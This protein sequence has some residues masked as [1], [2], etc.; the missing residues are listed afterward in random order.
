MEKSP[1]SQHDQAGGSLSAWRFGWKSFVFIYEHS[2]YGAIQSRVLVNQKHKS[3]VT[4]LSYVESK[5]GND[6]R[7]GV[8]GGRQLI[9]TE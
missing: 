2:Q 9:R 7:L 4:E 6:H 8:S 5:I 1:S 3:R